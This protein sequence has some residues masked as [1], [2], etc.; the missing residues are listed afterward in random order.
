MLI[1]LSNHP[2][3]YWGELQ[4]R[5]A[6][7]QWGEVE[8]IPF[9]AI[10]PNLSREELLPIVDD[11]LGKCMACA[12]RY[13]DGTAFHIMGESVFCFHL[14]NKLLAAGYRVVASAATRDAEYMADGHKITMFN[15]V[16]FREY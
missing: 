9:P 12:I 5:E 16:R 4:R 3:I 2:Y 15:F 10:D 13:G 8:D 7:E 6:L 14:I 11:Y 1:N